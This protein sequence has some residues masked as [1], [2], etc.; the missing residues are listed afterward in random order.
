MP[1]SGV[2][3]KA[4]E[5][6]RYGWLRRNG[7]LLAAILAGLAFRCFHVHSRELQ[8]D[9]AA[10][11]YFAGLPWVDLWGGR[12]VL[13]PNPPLFY[14]LAWFVT[15]AGGSAEQI[16]YISVAAGVLSI[17]LAWLIARRLAGEFAAG[18]A[19]LL[20]ATSPQHIAISQYAR[21][22]A[23]LILCLMCAFY[24]LLRAKHPAIAQPAAWR[25][26]LP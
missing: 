19:A 4:V 11:G 3:S 5:A 2:R 26:R 9:E 12:A 24:C 25:Q 13:E 6:L 1:Q 21:A 8:Y 22:Y 23:V 7:E 17:P 14:S 16:R 15:H 20:V 10:T 18:A